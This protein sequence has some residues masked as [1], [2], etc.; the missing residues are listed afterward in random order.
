M[1]TCEFCMYAG[2]ECFLLQEPIEYDSSG[3]TVKSDCPIRGKDGNL[4][5]Q[6]DERATL[7]SDDKQD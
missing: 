7:R 6:N 4:Q 1:K 3:M 5:I 2:D